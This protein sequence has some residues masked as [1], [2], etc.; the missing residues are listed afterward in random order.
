MSRGLYFML[1]VKQAGTTPISKV[2]GIHDL[3]GG[4]A[5]VSITLQNEARIPR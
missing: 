5:L 2:F 3:H 4:V 1:S